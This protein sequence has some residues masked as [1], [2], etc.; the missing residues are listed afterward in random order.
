MLKRDKRH[1][2]NRNMLL[3]SDGFEMPFPEAVNSFPPLTRAIF[4]AMKTKVTSGDLVALQE[5]ESFEEGLID[6]YFKIFETINLML[7]KSNEYLKQQPKK[8]KS[9]DDQPYNTQKVLYCDTSFIQYHKM[10][11]PEDFAEF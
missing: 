7:L 5:G 2:A 10:N 3:D 6:I 11:A 9:G 4:E 1:E 8:T